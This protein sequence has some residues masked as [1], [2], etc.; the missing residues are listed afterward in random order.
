MSEQSAEY[1]T[2]VT[3]AAASTGAYSKDEEAY[4]AAVDEAT[5]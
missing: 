3:Q 4:Q 5:K 2:A 1:Q